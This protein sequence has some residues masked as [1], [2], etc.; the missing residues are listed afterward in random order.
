MNNVQ[1]SF[2]VVFLRISAMDTQFLTLGGNDVFHD[3]VL[4][5]QIIR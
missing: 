2:D 3:L 1:K 5:L 4:A